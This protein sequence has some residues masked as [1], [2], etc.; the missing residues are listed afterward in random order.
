MRS[1]L[2]FEPH[3]FIT[4]RHAVH[5][6]DEQR[7]NNETPW[8]LHCGWNDFIKQYNVTIWS[9][10]TDQ[11]ATL[12]PV[13]QCVRDQIAFLKLRQGLCHVRNIHTQYIIYFTRLL[14]CTF[15]SINN[16]KIITF[17]SRPSTKGC[18]SYHQYN[19]D[20]IITVTSAVVCS[21]AA[22]HNTNFN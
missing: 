10:Q 22:Q 18:A 21:S 1:Q 20:H 4:K 8:S 11:Y 13:T 14:Q 2:S 7:Y 15:T 17:T 9:I 19:V 5:T 12:V 3:P 6:V 16:T